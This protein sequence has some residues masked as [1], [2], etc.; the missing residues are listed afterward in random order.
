MRIYVFTGEVRVPA[1][2]EFCGSIDPAGG[3]V[4]A[5]ASH[6]DP[7]PIY[8]AIEAETFLDAAVVP[9]EKW[10]VD[11]GQLGLLGSLAS[12]TLYRTPRLV[13]GIPFDTPALISFPEIARAQEVDPKAQEAARVPALEGQ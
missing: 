13:A 8:K 12:V 2:G 10:F 7:R 1:A 3:V 6:T 9:C 11:P 5:S 4:P